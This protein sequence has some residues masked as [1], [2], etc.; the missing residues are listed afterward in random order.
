MRQFTPHT[1]DEAPLHLHAVPHRILRKWFTRAILKLLSAF[2]Q[3]YLMR[4]S[5]LQKNLAFQ[6]NEEVAGAVTY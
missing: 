3:V 2:Q 5:S 1:E 6:L 4:L